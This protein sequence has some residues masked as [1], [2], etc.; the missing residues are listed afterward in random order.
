MYMLNY[1]VNVSTSF[2]LDMGKVHT[3]I[4]IQ[5]LSTWAHGSWVKW[6][7]LESLSISTID[8]RATL[9]IIM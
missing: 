2:L 8:I 1:S 5:T 3:H 9:L 4:M 6:S 7:Q